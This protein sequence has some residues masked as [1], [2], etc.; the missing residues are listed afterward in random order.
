MATVAAVLDYSNMP[1]PL[2]AEGDGRTKSSSVLSQS[3]G[4]LQ[5]QMNGSATQTKSSSVLSRFLNTTT[6][7]PTETVDEEDLMETKSRITMVKSRMSAISS[8]VA[9]EVHKMERQGG[10]HELDAFEQQKSLLTTVMRHLARFKVDVRGRHFIVQRIFRVLE[11]PVTETFLLWLIFVDM[12]CVGI[13]F[14]IDLTFKDFD[15]HRRLAGS[16]PRCGDYDLASSISTGAR[17]LSITILCTFVSEMLL[18]ACLAPSH[19][20]HAIFVFD[21]LIVSTSLIM[22][23]TLH[24]SEG[25]LIVLFRLWRL[26]RILH[27][28]LDYTHEMY[29]NGRAQALLAFSVKQWEETVADLE[30]ARERE[31]DAM[32]FIRDKQAYK[33]FVV[34]CLTRGRDPDKSTGSSRVPPITMARETSPVSNVTSNGNANLAVPL[35]GTPAKPSAKK[36][37][38]AE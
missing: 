11:A 37:A 30:V 7:N 16:G 15:G 10:L 20:K 8:R 3:D 22:E 27:G 32:E 24:H 31:R 25:T 29:E 26:V 9:T 33:E 28:F 36:V 21:F 12:M 13:E 17:A 5:A 34:Y 4:Q 2:L 35:P 18:R 23:L 38:V 14:V 1:P 6:N 19:L